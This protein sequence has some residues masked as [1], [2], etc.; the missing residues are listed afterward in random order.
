MLTFHSFATVQDARNYRHNHG[1]GGW[2]FAA[3]NAPANKPAVILFPPAMTPTA[4]LNHPL[5]KGLSGKLLAN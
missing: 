5:T 4:I 1:K 3:D 2:I